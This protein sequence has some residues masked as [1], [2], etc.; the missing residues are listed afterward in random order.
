[1]T[2]GGAIGKKTEGPKYR[3]TVTSSWWS[4]TLFRRKIHDLK[5][6]GDHLDYYYSG[7]LLE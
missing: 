3:D 7:T 6:S 1:M 4:Y 2:Q 5:F